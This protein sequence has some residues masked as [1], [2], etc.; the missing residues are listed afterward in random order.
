MTDWFIKAGRLLNQDRIDAAADLV[1]ARVLVSGVSSTDEAL[2]A[3]ALADQLLETTLLRIHAQK[4]IAS[5]RDEQNID[6]AIG[7]ARVILPASHPLLAQFIR[8]ASWY[9]DALQA[10]AAQLADRLA[11]SAA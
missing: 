6:T 7:L 10:E 8:R 4:D 3:Y 9:R 1:A 11:Q 5:P 2:L